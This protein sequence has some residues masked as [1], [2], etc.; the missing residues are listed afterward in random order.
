MLA[1]FR[2]SDLQEL[3]RAFGQSV[4][5]SKGIYFIIYHKLIIFIINILFI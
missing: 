3:L 2:V 4:T 5:F 1:S